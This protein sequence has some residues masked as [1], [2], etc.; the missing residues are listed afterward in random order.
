MSTS[1]KPPSTEQL[2]TQLAYLKLLFIRE[3]YAS[4]AKGKIGDRPHLFLD[5]T[6]KRG[7]SPI[8]LVP[9]SLRQYDAKQD[10]VR[11]PLPNPMG[12]L[13]GFH[14]QNTN[15]KADSR[16]LPMDK[17]CRTPAQH[18]RMSFRSVSI[19]YPHSGDFRMRHS[20]TYQALAVAELEPRQN[21]FRYLHHKMV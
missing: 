18:N 20:S 2:N 16:R 15:E 13:F 19:E 1:N 3:H 6:E 8:P 4:L 21:S 14:L 11:N 9:Y 12:L 7:L 17:R 5:S 10:E